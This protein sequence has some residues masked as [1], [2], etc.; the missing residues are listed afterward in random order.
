M[1]KASLFCFGYCCCRTR[2]TRPRRHRSVP[3]ETD[4]AEARRM[5]PAPNTARDHDQKM[6]DRITKKLPES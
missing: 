6:V 4:R 1:K 5:G 3:D 2:V